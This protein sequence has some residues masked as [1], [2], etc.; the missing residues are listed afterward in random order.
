A[1]SQGRWIHSAVCA[2]DDEIGNGR[3]SAQD[4][5]LMAV[6]TRGP[7]I[8]ATCHTADKAYCVEFHASPWFS[9]A[10]APSI[11]DLAPRG[12]SG[13]AIAECLESRPGYERLHDL[14]QY[15]AKR[16]QP[17]SVEDPTWNTFECIV[18]RPEAVAW[19]EKNRPDVVARIPSQS[20]SS[21]P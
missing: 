12:W 15:A 11:V 4:P 20:R 9:A 16:L 5:R 1:R 19:L 14:I 3:T 13:A 18:D 7:M 10:C 21:Q 8:P 6:R 2:T 17:E